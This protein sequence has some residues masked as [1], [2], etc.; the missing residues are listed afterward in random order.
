MRRAA[1]ILGLCV[2]GGCE[3]V[4]RA[5][6]QSADGDRV[7]VPA[8][9]VE[10]I[11]VYPLTHF[12]T[13]EAGE[14]VVVLHFELLDAFRDPL[15][16]PGRLRVVALVPITPSG[17][18]LRNALSWDVDLADPAVNSRYFDTATQT[19]RVRLGQ[20]SGEV[21]AALSGHGPGGESGFVELGVTFDTTGPDGD[22]SSLRNRYVLR[23]EVQDG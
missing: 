16:A 2:C 7:L 11:R 4:P 8:F 9:P 1:A 20:L 19:Y 18:E 12:D 17:R 13:T 22:P 15:K 3:S 21:V 14:P 23:A 6:G 10:E 5:G